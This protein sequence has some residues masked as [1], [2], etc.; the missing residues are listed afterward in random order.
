MDMALSQ[1]LFW[2][3]N[4]VKCPKCDDTEEFLRADVEVYIVLGSGEVLKS[5]YTEKTL[6]HRCLHCGYQW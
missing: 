5:E 4:M 1:P 3:E 2:G 6:W